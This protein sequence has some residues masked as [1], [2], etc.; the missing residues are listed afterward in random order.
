MRTKHNDAAGK[1]VAMPPG[2]GAKQILIPGSSPED[3]LS[4]IYSY[5]VNQM[6]HSRLRVPPKE[7]R[8]TFLHQSMLMQSSY[9]ELLLNS[10][11]LPEAERET[12][13][14]NYEE[15]FWLTG[16]MSAF[17]DTF[18]MLVDNLP[19][20]FPFIKVINYQ[21]KS[22]KME[23]NQN[24]LVEKPK[25]SDAELIAH[26]LGGDQQEAV[27][28]ILKKYEQWKQQF[29]VDSSRDLSFDILQDS[30]KAYSV[31]EEE[32]V[33]RVVVQNAMNNWYKSAIFFKEIGVMLDLLEKAY[34]AKLPDESKGNE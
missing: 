23:T 8:F 10:V 28:R 1:A 21:F 32:A 11:D 4:Q 27:N 24:H 34:G 14:K 15:L 17:I 16:E 7:L 3:G 13:L 2:M 6:K 18:S 30:F 33:D 29:I 26:Y 12:L 31:L 9:H 25:Q 5:L 22:L 19:K 20:T